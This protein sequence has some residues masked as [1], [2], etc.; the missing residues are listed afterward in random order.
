MKPAPFTY[1]APR[2][3]E[4]AVALLGALA[5]EGGR[6]LA[7]GQSL[8]PIMAFRLAQPT[9]L[10]DINRIPGLD[11]VAVDGDRLSVGAT[12]RHAAFHAWEAPGPLGGLLA[13]VAAHIG[14]GPIRARG[15]L[16][17]SLAHAD[18]ASEWCLVFSTLGGEMIAHGSRGSRVI[19]ASDWF[20]GIMT[21]ALAE[22]EMLVE[23]RLKLPPDN[24]R[25]GF[26]EQSRRAGDFAMAAALVTYRLADGRII[27]P[28]IGIGGAEPIPRRIAAAEAALDGHAPQDATFARAADA[29]AAA[30]EPMEDKQI[31]VTLRRDLVR[32]S[33]RRALRLS[34]Q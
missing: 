13:T 20:R 27:E 23:A 19:D 22:D 29:A 11:R 32:A 24:A 5:P 26:C 9:H 7:G 6:I 34:L 30:I 12:V 14:H 17:G 10:I 2:S 28:R 1:H 31:P 16:C 4:Q 18:P 15:T 33:T 21:T 8:V 3:V 25:F